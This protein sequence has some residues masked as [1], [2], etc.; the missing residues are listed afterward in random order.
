M[1]L[2]TTNQKQAINEYAK[3]GSNGFWGEK[4]LLKCVFS[5]SLSFSQ[6]KNAIW[7]WWCLR[8][9]GE[10]RNS[11]FVFPGA[12]SCLKGEGLGVREGLC[13]S[14]HNRVFSLLQ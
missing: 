3:M 12:Q 11:I 4:Y 9:Q 13:S 1:I 7:R 6:K 5:L 10:K 14:D 8:Q 2:D